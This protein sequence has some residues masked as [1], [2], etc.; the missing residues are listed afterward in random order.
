MPTK[1][2]IKELLA[3]AK[4]FID[5]GTHNDASAPQGSQAPQPQ[6]GPAAAGE[7]PMM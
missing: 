2:D 6:G 5:A 7:N 1:P 4:S 3:M